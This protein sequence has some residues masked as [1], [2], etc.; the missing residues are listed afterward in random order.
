MPI[1]IVSF[2]LLFGFYVVFFRDTLIVVIWASG[3]PS[4]NM[5]SDSDWFGDLMTSA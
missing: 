1:L 4:I 2:V 3:C 5:K